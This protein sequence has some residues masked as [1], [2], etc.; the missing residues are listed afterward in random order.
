V[1][2]KVTVLYDGHQ[3]Y[4]GRCS[5]ARAFFT[6][7]GFEPAPRQTTADFLTSLTSP[8]ERIVKPGFEDKTPRTAAEFASAWK[9]S[10]EYA[11]LIR[12]IEAYDEKY[13]IGGP[14]VAE[15]TLS[16]RAQQAP[17]Q[18]VYHCHYHYITFAS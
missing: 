16:R 1:F 12:D 18:Y 9:R 2:D 13:P 15:F 8:A 6:R 17:H 10:P 4:F 11:A 14:S 5:E 7:M 3:I